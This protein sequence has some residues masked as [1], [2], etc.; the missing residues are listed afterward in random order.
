MRSGEADGKSSQLSGL[1]FSCLLFFSWVSHWLGPL[2]NNAFVVV[3]PHLLDLCSQV[4][5]IITCTRLLVLSLTLSI[6]VQG[7]T[8]HIKV[9]GIIGPL[10]HQ[11]WKNKSHLNKGLNIIWEN[12]DKINTIFSCFAPISFLFP[13]TKPKWGL[14]TKPGP[15]VP[16][17]FTLMPRPPFILL[18]SCTM[19]RSA[20][21]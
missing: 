9:W 11:L 12:R 18:Q 6:K 4:R 17:R 21:E 1:F 20:P 16:N 2:K 10:Q 14:D 15:W 19:Q 7:K 8:W 5:G 3:F 13:S